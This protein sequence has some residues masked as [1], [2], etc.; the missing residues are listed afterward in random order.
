LRGTKVV[1]GYHIQA[2][3]GEIGHVEDFII[4]DENWAVRR[5]ALTRISVCCGICRPIWVVQSSS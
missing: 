3:D 5:A 1:T 2:S 4:D